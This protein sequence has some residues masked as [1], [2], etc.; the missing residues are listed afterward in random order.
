MTSAPPHVWVFPFGSSLVT[1]PHGKPFTVTWVP[2]KGP[3]YARVVVRLYF[4]T[5]PDV[6]LGLKDALELVVK[7]L[8]PYF[9]GAVY[10]GVVHQHILRMLARAA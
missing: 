9:T 8:G 2:Q 6:P 7:A 1:D 10:V 5:T 4:P 3:T